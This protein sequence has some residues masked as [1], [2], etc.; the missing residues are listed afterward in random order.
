MSEGHQK[1]RYSEKVAAFASSEIFGNNR[2]DAL[3]HVLYHSFLLL[4]QAIVFA[5]AAGNG[6]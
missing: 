4:A 6:R 2:Y 3:D 5:V 1:S